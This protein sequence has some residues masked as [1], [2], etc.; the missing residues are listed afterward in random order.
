MLDIEC[1]KDVDPGGDDFLDIEISLGMSAARRV[2][3][4]E[5]IDKHDLGVALED[6]V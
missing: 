3:M 4:G 5:L 2:G 6:R 1:R